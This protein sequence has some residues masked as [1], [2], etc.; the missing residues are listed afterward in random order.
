MSS[1]FFRGTTAD[2]DYRFGDKHKQQLKAID[3]TA[4]PIYATKVRGGKSRGRRRR[5]HRA[6]AEGP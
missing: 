3:S 5:T 4:P 6:L 1:N 2:Q